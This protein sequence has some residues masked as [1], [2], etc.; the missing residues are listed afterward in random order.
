MTDCLAIGD[1]AP[2]PAPGPHQEVIRPGPP[3]EGERKSL[4]SKGEPL[5]GPRMDRERG[6][7]II[8]RRPGQ[9]GLALGPGVQ[10]DHPLLPPELGEAAEDGA[11]ATRG[12]GPDP[13]Q[14]LPAQSLRATGRELGPNPPEGAEPAP[15]HSPETEESG[16]VQED[17]RVAREQAGLQGAPIVAIHDPGVPGEE[18]HAPRPPFT[19]ARGSP[20]RPPV[21]RIEVNDRDPGAMA[22][23]AGERRLAAPAGADYEDALHWKG[24]A[25]PPQVLRA[26]FMPRP[27][28]PRSGS[29]AWLRR[30]S[31][32]RI[33]DPVRHDRRPPGPLARESSSGRGHGPRRHARPRLPVA[34]LRRPDSPRRPTRGEPPRGDTRRGTACPVPHRHSSPRY[35]AGR[36]RR[37]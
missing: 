23:S 1:L 2:R 35:R 21:V 25:W 18:L 32:A 17:H 11:A 15:E 36:V 6:L 37:L 14:E 34:H 4:D 28:P 12:I 20:A 16:Q 8:R 10:D 33:A 30:P 29:R 9:E 24:R 26:G 22:E 5:R 31:R 19:R 27:A 13:H 3:R 7:G